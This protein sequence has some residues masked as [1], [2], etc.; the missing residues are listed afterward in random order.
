MENDAKI[1]G[2]IRVYDPPL[3]NSFPLIPPKM[4]HSQLLC[5]SWG[6][7]KYHKIPI[8]F[9]ANLLVGAFVAHITNSFGGDSHS[10]GWACNSGDGEDAFRRQ[11]GGCGG[12]YLIAPHAARGSLRG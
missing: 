10:G 7:Y 4:S 11:L 8:P 5:L 9:I 1:F 3:T 6:L 12:W 2:E